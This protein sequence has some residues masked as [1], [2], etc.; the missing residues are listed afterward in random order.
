[1]LGGISALPRLRSPA[2]R[3]TMRSALNW[4]RSST[5][6]ASSIYPERGHTLLIT[7][8]CFFALWS[9]ASLLISGVKDQRL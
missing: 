7:F 5:I 6:P 9:S 2:S 1:M 8:F 3:S 4:P